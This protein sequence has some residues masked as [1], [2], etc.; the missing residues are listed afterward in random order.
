MLV[1]K[2]RRCCYMVG[3]RSLLCGLDEIPS[4]VTAQIFGETD[5]AIHQIFGLKPFQ[6]EIGAGDFSSVIVRTNGHDHFAAIEFSDPRRKFIQW[7]VFDKAKAVSLIFLRKADVDDLNLSLFVE[8]EHLGNVDFHIFPL[9][10]VKSLQV[11]I[12]GD[13]LQVLSRQ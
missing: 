7:N 1:G 10:V 4:L 6:G 12:E 2:R 9:F 8:I 3:N 11:V 5:N 13:A